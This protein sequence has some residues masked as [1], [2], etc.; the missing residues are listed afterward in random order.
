MIDVDKYL[1]S[2]WEDVVKIASVTGASVEEVI[3]GY[4]RLAFGFN[5]KSNNW[6]K[7]HGYPKRRKAANDE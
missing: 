7:M 3:E 5:C 2:R 1:K 6:L 4:R